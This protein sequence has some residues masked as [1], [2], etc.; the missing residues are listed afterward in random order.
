MANREAVKA[1]SRGPL[2]RANGIIDTPIISLT[3]VTMLLFDR[4]VFEQRLHSFEPPNPSSLPTP[5]TL[6]RRRA[7]RFVIELIKYLENR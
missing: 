2:G 3:V 1:C 4:S 5:P 6:V 7:A